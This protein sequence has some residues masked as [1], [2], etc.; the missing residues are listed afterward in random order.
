[1]PSFGNAFGQW[2]DTIKGVAKSPYDKLFGHEDTKAALDKASTDA[3]GLAA[4]DKAYQEKGLN[5]SLGYFG[6]SQDLLN[7]QKGALSGPSLSEK[8][9]ADLQG[10]NDPY[11]NYM[12]D[13]GNRSLGNTFAAQG[14]FNSGAHDQAQSDFQANLAAQQSQQMSGLAGQADQEQRGRLGDIFGRQ[15][16]ISQGQAGA[17]AGAYGIGG[18]LANKDSLAA[19][20]AALQKGGLDEKSR[21]DLIKTAITLL[22][23]GAA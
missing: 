13:K 14:G 16:G 6:Q 5:A 23:A 4:S 10:G 3:A 7:S 19:I 18:A 8:R 9:Y 15:F 17:T 12:L 21:D 20:E 1:M 11:F 2:V 22:A